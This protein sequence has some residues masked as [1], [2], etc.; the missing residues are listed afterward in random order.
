MSEGPTNNIIQLSSKK[1]LWGCAIVGLAI[2]IIG[3][4]M[5]IPSWVVATEVLLTVLGLFVFGSIKYRLDKN[6]LTYGAFI[7]IAA[8]FFEPWWQQSELKA[9][10]LS[11]GMSVVFGFFH[12]HFLTLHGLDELIHA[13]TMLFIL[14]LTYFVAVIAQTRL[15]ETVSFKVLNFNKGGV[16]ATVGILTALVSVASGILDGVS[17]IGL[18]IRTLVIILFLAKETF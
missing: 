11:D 15:L 7:I 13:D 12:H 14:G 5:T 1:F 10:I 18:M 9:A 16:L 4:T 6:A 8:T 17:M 2:L 3:K